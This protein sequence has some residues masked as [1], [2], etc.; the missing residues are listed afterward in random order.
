MRILPIEDYKGPTRTDQQFLQPACPG[1][2]PPERLTIVVEDGYVTYALGRD[3]NL[4]QMRTDSQ[5][6]GDAL[7]SNAVV[8]GVHNALNK[9]REK[10]TDHLNS[11]GERIVERLQSFEPRARWDVSPGSYSGSPGADDE[12][13]WEEIECSAEL[14]E[15]AEFGHQ[16]YQGVFRPDSRLRT[17]VDGLAGGA[18]LEIQWQ[19]NSKGRIPNLPW[20]LMYAEPPAPKGNP[21]DPRH[22]LG[23]RHRISYLVNY[24]K[25]D[26]GLGNH[27]M[28]I[29]FWAGDDE[30]LAESRLQ[31]GLWT[32]PETYHV[33][34]GEPGHI[35]CDAAQARSTLINSLRQP[36]W[37]PLAI[38][39]LFCKGDMFQDQFQLYFSGGE[40]EV[41][42]AAYEIPSNILQDSPL[43]FVNACKAGGAPDPTIGN[44]LEQR[45]LDRSCRAF[46]AP[47]NYIPIRLASSFAQVFFH[48]L[49]GDRLGKPIKAG[50]AAAQSRR[51]LWEEFRNIGG[52]FYAYVNDY[53]VYLADGDELARKLS[54]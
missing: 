45:F 2:L 26:Q 21:I 15:L 18:M 36:P 17:R 19:R 43:V 10:F 1:L 50:E 23:L 31:H 52:L 34:P 30:T 8:V 38:I 3:G 12:R 13:R 29:Y 28:Y 37:G 53:H 14:W 16:L 40:Q 22:F 24:T 51:F 25:D 41:A 35:V 20:T 32:G 7:A 54:T 9:F 49:R 6:G 4:G 44:P 39:Y 47:V 5:W 48:F 11:V 33:V 46:L 27:G 42:L